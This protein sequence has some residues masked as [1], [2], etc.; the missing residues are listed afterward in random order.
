MVGSCTEV[1]TRGRGHLLLQQLEMRLL[2]R[3][4]RDLADW[5]SEQ[6]LAYSVQADFEVDCRHLEG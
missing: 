4:R 5:M 3:A 2:A 1:H 6:D